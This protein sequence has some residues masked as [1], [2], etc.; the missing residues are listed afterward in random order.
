MA[1]NASPNIDAEEAELQRR[2]IAAAFRSKQV[3]DA[4]A[5]GVLQRI[6]VAYLDYSCHDWN[7]LVIDWRIIHNR[8][9]AYAFAES[10][11]ESNDIEGAHRVIDV[12][13]DGPNNF[14]NWVDTVRDET[15]AKRITI[16]GLPIKNDRNSFSRFSLPDLDQYYRGCV[17]GGPGAFLV[18][19]R[20][21]HDFVRA[22]RKISCWKLP[23]FRRCGG[24]CLFARS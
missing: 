3:I 8:E 21:F 23:G 22:I 11:I 4:I 18:V 24:R 13:G 6:A 20:N 10:L 17:I 9:S 16:N 7:K 1:T 14:G 12:S 15:I 5:S 19:A 2:G